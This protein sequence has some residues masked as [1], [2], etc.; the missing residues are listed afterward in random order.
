MDREVRRI[1]EFYDRSK[2]TRESE[3]APPGLQKC[4]PGR[5]GLGH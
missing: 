3:Q 1:R 2:L 4:D 5:E